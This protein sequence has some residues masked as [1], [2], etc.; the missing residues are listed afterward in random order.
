MKQ[1]EIDE[2]I[3]IHRPKIPT[4]ARAWG[5]FTLMLLP[6]EDL[7]ALPDGTI[8]IDIWGIP[9]IKGSDKLD[10]DTRGGVTAY[11]FLREDEER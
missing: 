7:A 2:I 6:P 5:K 11:G 1:E 9:R 3:G 4:S 10:D 8:V